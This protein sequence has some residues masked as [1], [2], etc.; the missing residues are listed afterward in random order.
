MS[1]D[2]P[3]TLMAIFGIFLLVLTAY[4]IAVL[5]VALVSGR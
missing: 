5:I 1:D 3:D 4:S 2:R